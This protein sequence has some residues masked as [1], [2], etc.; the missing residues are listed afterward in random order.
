ML[1][2]VSQS[3]KDKYHTISLICRIKEA[4]QMNTG[5]GKRE[6]NQKN[7]FLNIEKRLM[8]V[9]HQ[10]EGGQGMGQRHDGY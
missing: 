4:K 5:G 1:R 2:E 10:R 3:E 9:H 8:A 6:A 7:R